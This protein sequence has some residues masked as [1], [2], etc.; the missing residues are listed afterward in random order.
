MIEPDWVL[1]QTLEMH[2]RDLEATEKEFEEKLEKAR[3]NERRMREMEQVRARKRQ[4]MPCFHTIRI[5][6]E[7]IGR[8]LLIKTRM[9]S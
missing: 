6:A 7:H 1:E 3:K 9:T 5:T 2:R 8:K 4:V